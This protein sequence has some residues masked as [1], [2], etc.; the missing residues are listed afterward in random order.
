MIRR[1]H[2]PSGKAKLFRREDL[3][4][5]R[6]RDIRIGRPDFRWQHECVW[7]RHLQIAFQAESHS[8]A[9]EPLQTQRVMFQFNRPNPDDDF[10]PHGLIDRHKESDEVDASKQPSNKLTNDVHKKVSH[11]LPDLEETARNSLASRGHHP[12]ERQER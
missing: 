5:K 2:H 1:R 10:E 8:K 4:R 12:F 6:H 9:G 11:G 7:E 3:P